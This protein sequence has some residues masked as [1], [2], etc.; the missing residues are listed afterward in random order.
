MQR[1]QKKNSERE[2]NHGGGASEGG[3]AQT[4]GK[5]CERW[6]WLRATGL[7]SLLV[8]QTV[9]LLAIAYVGT[10]RFIKCTRL[11]IRVVSG[12][13]LAKAVGRAVS[14]SRCG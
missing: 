14:L 5:R 10:T 11:A 4:G 13:R 9:K 3:Q 1:W 8:L 7:E 6:F 12:A 2:V